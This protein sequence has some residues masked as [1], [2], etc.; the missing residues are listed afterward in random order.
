[1]T[2]IKRIYKKRAMVKRPENT[3]RPTKGLVRYGRKRSD[4][5]QSRK[6]FSKKKDLNEPGQGGSICPNPCE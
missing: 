2:G 4:R 3:E 6:L 5:S 1:M